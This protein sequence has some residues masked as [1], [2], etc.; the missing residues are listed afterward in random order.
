VLSTAMGA[1]QIIFFSA[2]DFALGVVFLYERTQF[3]R[4]FMKKI[5]CLAAGLLALNLTPVFGQQPGSPSTFAERLTAIQAK[6]A[7]AKANAPGLTKF[8]LDFP[9]GTAKQLVAAIE[10]ALGKP[11]NVIVPTD[12]KSAKVMLPPIKVNDMDVAR[13]FKALEENKYSDERF[14]GIPQNS[15]VKRIT[16]YTEDGN[17]SDNSLWKFVY[18]EKASALTAF[19]LDFHG[20]PPSILVKEIEKA[21]GKPLNVVISPEDDQEDLPPL[22]MNNVYL[23]QLFTA[24]ESASRKT[25]SVPSQNYPGGYSQFSASY[26]F[27]TADTTTD[28]S[29]WYFHV[30]KPL[31]PPVVSTQKVCQY[32]S[33]APHLYRGFTVDDITTAIQTG[34]KMAGITPIPELS[35]HKET[36]ML[37]AFG[38]P[39]NLKTVDDVLKTLPQTF[40]DMPTVA[41]QIKKLQE[42]VDLLEKRRLEA[43]LLLNKLSSQP[44]APAVAPE[45]KSAK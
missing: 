12:E 1:W 44:A 38:E 5:L 15:L 36:K 19:S 41:D 39:S 27:K 37:I 13:L 9:G 14:P 34:W 25:I 2:K 26:A 23:P 11:L 40:Y 30:E 45:E 20:G 17:P 6:D 16:F 28:T 8:N 21:I 43:A 31:L 33:L 35:Y 29:V 7:A 32:Y 42:Q 10:K 18:Y 4:P 3:N 24:L 22:K